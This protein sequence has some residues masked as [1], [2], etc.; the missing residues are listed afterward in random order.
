M[1]LEIVWF[2]FTLCLIIVG[3]IKFFMTCAAMAR[4]EITEDILAVFV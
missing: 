2:E 3:F 4:A 1:T